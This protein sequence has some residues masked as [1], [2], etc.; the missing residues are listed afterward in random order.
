MRLGS[1]MIWIMQTGI[2]IRKEFKERNG[3]TTWIDFIN[4]LLAMTELVAMRME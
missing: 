2:D 4:D 3:Q 1:W